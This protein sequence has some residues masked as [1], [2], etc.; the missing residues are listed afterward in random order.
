MIHAFVTSL[1]GALVRRNRPET[2]IRAEAQQKG[3]SKADAD[4]EVY[5]GITSHPTH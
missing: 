2:E 3:L 5:K 1:P 4:M